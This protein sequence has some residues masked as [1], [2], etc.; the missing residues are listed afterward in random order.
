MQMLEKLEVGDSVD[1]K[2]PQGPIVYTAPGKY[3]HGGVEHSVARINMVAGGTG[4][5]PLYQI[6]SAVLNNPSDTTEIRLMY[7]NNTEEDILL[8]TELETLEEENPQRFKLHYTVCEPEEGWEYS[9]GFVNLGMFRKHLF[10]AG[11]G[12]VTMLCGPQPMVQN[13]CHPNLAQMGF[14]EGSTSIEF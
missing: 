3:T 5:T 10:G 12:T 14:V 2:G 1:V 6:I 13:A 8:R 11:E 4:I 7:A 9:V